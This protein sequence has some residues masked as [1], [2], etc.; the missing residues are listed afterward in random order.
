M[1]GFL[2][3]GAA[4]HDSEPGHCETLRDGRDCERVA[5]G[6][7]KT[8][9]ALGTLPSPSIP[10]LHR[11]SL[12]IVPDRARGEDSQHQHRNWANQLGVSEI[13]PRASWLVRT[14]NKIPLQS[15]SEGA[16]MLSAFLHHV[17]ATCFGLL[18][19]KMIVHLFFIPPHL[20]T[21][22]GVLAGCLNA[23]LCLNLT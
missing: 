19:V 18:E 23:G 17:S 14:W 20:D 13:V 2:S 3:A 7:K 5:L 1:R 21:S 6:G 15:F 22:Q 9:W 11:A 8:C 12:R 4:G 10:N 16:S